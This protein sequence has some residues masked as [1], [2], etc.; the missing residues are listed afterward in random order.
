MEKFRYFLM[1]LGAAV[2]FIFLLLLLTGVKI[3]GTILMWILGAVAI[4]VIIGWII[5]LIGKS[6]GK[7]EAGQTEL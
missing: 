1:I 7:R 5:Y 6:R 2:I 4:F 3:A